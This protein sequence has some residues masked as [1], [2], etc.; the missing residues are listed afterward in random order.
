MP[1]QTNNCLI[2]VCGP[3]PMMKALC[4]NK[5][6]DKQQGQLIGHLN[7]MAYIKE[8]VFKF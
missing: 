6:P 5:T 7:D 2:Y 1:E 3:P 4:G 8:Q